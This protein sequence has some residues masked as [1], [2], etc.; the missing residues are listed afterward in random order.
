MVFV[1]KTSYLK[2][3]GGTGETAMWKCTVG[4]CNEQVA[5]HNG[6]GNL[7][8]HVWNNHLDAVHQ[9]INRNSSRSSIPEQQVVDSNSLYN[10]WAIVIYSW[11]NWIVMC[12]LPF[13]WVDNAIARRYSAIKGTITYKTFIKYLNLVAQKLLGKMASILPDKFCIM[14]DG[15]Y[16]V[17]VCLLL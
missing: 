15:W 3:Q 10:R 6:W 5:K 7:F 8:S 4:N 17:S 9:V 11:L 13:S 1:K 12:N 2:K 14:F 16:C